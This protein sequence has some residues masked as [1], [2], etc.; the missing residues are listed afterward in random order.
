ML[1]HG[2]YC[3]FAPLCTSFCTLHSQIHFKHRT[4]SHPLLIYLWVFF[5]ENSEKLSFVEKWR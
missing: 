5:L 4:L 1:K 3:E 2:H